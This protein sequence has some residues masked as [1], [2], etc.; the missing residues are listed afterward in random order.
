MPHDMFCP[1]KKIISCTFR[2]SGTLIAK[3][4]HPAER[5]YKAGSVVEQDEVQL[6]EELLSSRKYHV[7]VRWRSW[8]YPTGIQLRTG[9]PAGLK[10]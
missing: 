9:Q 3:I 6:V 4:T 8:Q 10:I 7:D 2:I 1:R 5:N